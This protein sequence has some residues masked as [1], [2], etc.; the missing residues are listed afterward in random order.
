MLIVKQLSTIDLF[1]FQNNYLNFNGK[2]YRQISGTSMGKKVAP[3]LS[4]LVMAF[5]ETHMYER[6]KLQFG[7]KFHKY[8]LDH[9]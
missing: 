9:L 7:F 6:P 4:H 5:F 2:S 3:I 8:I 1:P